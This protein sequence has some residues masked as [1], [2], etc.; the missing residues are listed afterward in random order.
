MPAPAPSPDDA[1]T[2]PTAEVISFGIFGAEAEA[3]R[4][5]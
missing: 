4:W 2:E 1:P 5:I 3:E